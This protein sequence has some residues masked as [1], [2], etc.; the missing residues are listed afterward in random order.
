MCPGTGTGNTCYG[1]NAG[2]ALT[3]GSYNTAL[4]RDAL[5][6]NSTGVGNVGV[7]S[8]AGANI[9]TGGNNIAI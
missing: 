3:T 1:F 8:G 2:I 7:G 4:G 9:T 6:L 5:R